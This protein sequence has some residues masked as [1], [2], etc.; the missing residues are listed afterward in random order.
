MKSLGHLWRGF[1]D[2]SPSAWV[3][4]AAN[5]LPLTGVLMFDWDTFSVVAL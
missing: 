4:V 2:Y 3:L 1:W 5:V